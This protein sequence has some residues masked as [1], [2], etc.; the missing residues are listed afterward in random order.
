[1]ATDIILG[2][3]NTPP[4]RS[5]LSVRKGDNRVQCLS[6]PT[7]PTHRHYPAEMRATFVA[8]C[9]QEG[10]V[11]RRKCSLPASFLHMV[12]DTAPIVKRLTKATVL[13]ATTM[14][15]PGNGQKFVTNKQ[16]SKTAG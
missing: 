12:L 4:I 14:T 7:S 9:P 15:N 11:L 2:E 16:H 8:P 3:K 1:M 10:C 6:I 5:F 13:Q